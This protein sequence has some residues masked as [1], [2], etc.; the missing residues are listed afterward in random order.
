MTAFGVDAAA[1]VNYAIQIGDA[2]LKTD[3][4]PREGERRGRAGG[5]RHPP[6]T[7]ANGASGATA[8]R[9][10]PPKSRRS[11]RPARRSRLLRYLYWVGLV[12]RAPDRPRVPGRLGVHA[13]GRRRDGRSPRLGAVD[14]ALAARPGRHRPLHG[15]RRGRPL[16]RAPS[17]ALCPSRASAA[18]LRPA[19]PCPRALRA[20]PARSSSTKRRRSSPSTRRA[21]SGT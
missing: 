3:E 21:W 13:V 8:Y 9:S 19:A 15:V 10:P 5:E 1:V 6:G 20:G 16:G 14:R 2:P 11:P 4:A 18:S 12:R 7:T 17:A